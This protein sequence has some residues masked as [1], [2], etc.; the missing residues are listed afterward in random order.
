MR[1]TDLIIADLEKDGHLL[2]VARTAVIDLLEKD[3]QL[4]QDKNAVI[5]QQVDRQKKSAINW[6]RTS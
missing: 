3:P 6:N 4:E 1:V 2:Q 5:Q